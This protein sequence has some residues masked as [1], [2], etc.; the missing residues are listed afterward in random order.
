M[1]CGF[2]GILFIL[3]IEGVVLWEGWLTGRDILD[4]VWGYLLHQI[5]KTS[6]YVPE[7]ETLY[8][9]LQIR[10][11]LRKDM[12]SHIKPLTSQTCQQSLCSLIS[13]HA[14][15]HQLVSQKCGQSAS[16]QSLPNPQFP[17]NGVAHRLMPAPYLRYQFSDKVGSY[18]WKCTKKFWLKKSWK[19]YKK[20]LA[21]ST[22]SAMWE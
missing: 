15:W 18:S 4:G 17:S 1:S 5:G 20:I 9:I 11:L 3:L 12:F 13:P 2:P 21:G 14:S 7:S 10:L 6:L 8:D 22:D 16:Q 19:M